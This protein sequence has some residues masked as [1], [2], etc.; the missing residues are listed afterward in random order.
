MTLT[1]RVYERYAVNTFL[2]M[3]S[4]IHRQAYMHSNLCLQ[5]IW[6]CNYSD[7]FCSNKESFHQAYRRSSFSN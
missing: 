2:K 5:I 1:N 7:L 4:Y 6:T 3:F